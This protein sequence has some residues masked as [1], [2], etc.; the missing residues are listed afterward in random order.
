VAMASWKMGRTVNVEGVAVKLPQDAA[1]I[2]RGRYLFESRGCADCHGVD[3]A[4]RVFHDEGS[5][6]IAGPQLAPGAAS[7]VARYR[8]ADWDRAIRHGVD[9]SGRP[10]MVMPAEDYNRLTDADLGALVAYVKRMPEV[11]GRRGEVV[12]PLPVRVLYGFGMIQDA[13]A[14]IDHSLPPQQPV[15]EGPTA[16]HGR[17]VANM[18]IG[19]HGPGLSGGKIPG[20]PPDW[21]AAANLTPGEGGT[22]GRYPDAAAF[23]AMLRSGKRPDGAAIAVM[24]FESLSKMS[25]VDVAALHAYLKTVPPRP[26]GQ[27]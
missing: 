4:G 1:A 18:C 7:A 9:P 25:E 2:D 5:M 3:G 10:L 24:P 13:A 17:Y 8:D 23:A 26:F 22:M 14:K 21:P 16:E 27:R 11:S 6:K 15:A 19:C 20:G 12:L